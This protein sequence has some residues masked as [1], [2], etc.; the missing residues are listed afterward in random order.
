[1]KP[2][3]AR[4]LLFGAI[5]P[6]ALVA[7]WSLTAVLEL[8][9]RTSLPAPWKVVEAFGVW[10]FGTGSGP[11]DGTWLEA[12]GA[13]GGR[14]LVGFA[15]AAILGV[16]LGVLAGYFRAFGEVVDPFVQM[17]RP[18]PSTAWVPLTLVFFGFGFSGAVFLIALGAFFPIFLNTM[19]GVR[20]V[21]GSLTR[22]GRML[23]SDTFQ[24]LRHFVVPASL[25]NIFI[26]VRLS[27]GLSWVLVVVA[28]M[29]S[30]R[31][32]IGYTLMDAYSLGRYDVIIAAMV[33]L[34]LLGF[35]SDRLIV[36]IQNSALKWHRE[37][38]IQD[39]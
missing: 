19:E 38:S 26:G 1:M 4:R 8:L 2:G 3:L 17:L 36:I 10:I 21:T 37:T 12:I 27:V 30:V 13:S 32:G 24:L 6:I 11:Y 31:S 7:V 29:L 15:V 28:E 18:I 22:V 20:G 16:V 14:V 34:G 23:G 25:P 39:A 9:P 33:T 5:L 35:L